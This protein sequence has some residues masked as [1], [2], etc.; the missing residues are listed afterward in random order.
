V[1]AITFAL[2]AESSNFL[3]LLGEKTNLNHHG[4]ATIRGTLGQLAIEVL[5]TGVGEKVSRQR[6]DRFL[7][8]RQFDYLISAGFAGALTDQLHS[9]DLLL[10]KNF[11]SVQLGQIPSELANMPAHIAVLH[12]SKQIIASSKERQ[13]IAQATGAVAV[14]MET[15]FIAQAS[16]GRALPMISLRVISDGLADP[17]PAPPELLF[18]IV[19][20]RTNAIKLAM[21]L[22]THPHR[23]PGLIQ[24]AKRIASARE[25]LTNAL[26]D[27][28]RTI[29]L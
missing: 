8:D 28:V 15:E 11:W 23:I 9:G 27:L 12:T 19:S 4:V 29:K 10:A 24:F 2:P 17:F 14:D 13:D 22:F 21:F 18:D 25:L 5:H 7:Q 3:R 26:V 6:L 16:A 20:Q 1:I